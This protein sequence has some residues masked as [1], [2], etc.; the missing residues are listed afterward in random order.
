MA[1][2]PLFPT[3]HAF[4]KINVKKL[5]ILLTSVFLTVVLMML[6][7]KS[8]VT[9]FQTLAMMERI[10]PT[11][12]AMLQL[13][14]AFI[15]T[16]NVGQCAR[17]LLTVIHGQPPALLLINVFK[18]LAIKLKDFVYLLNFLMLQNVQSNT[19]IKSALLPSVKP[20]LVPTTA[21]K[22]SFALLKTLT[23]T[24]KTTALLILAT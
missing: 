18:L 5:A 1:N 22:K 19:V 15:L 17:L 20:S 9:T 21:T 12:L 11:I 4:L 24:I 2:V 10:V 3:Q 13:V 14:S 16:P 23:V 8:F 7:T 6:T